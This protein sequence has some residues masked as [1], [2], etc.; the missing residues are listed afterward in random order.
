LEDEEES[1]EA[2]QE[3]AEEVAWLG[4]GLVPDIPPIACSPELSSAEVAE[5]FWTKI[6]V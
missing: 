2:T 6:G 3:V 1:V 5:D 4:L